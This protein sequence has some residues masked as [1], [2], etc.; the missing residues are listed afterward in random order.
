M[1]TLNEDLVDHN[2]KEVKE[3]AMIGKIEVAEMIETIT[4]AKEI[5][6]KIR[7]HQEA[8]MTIETL[9]TIVRYF[10]IEVLTLKCAYVLYTFILTIFI[11]YLI[12]VI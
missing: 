6:S 3:E 10:D 7:D 4:E 1:V 9:K 5:H 8:S 11:F 2:L 12:L